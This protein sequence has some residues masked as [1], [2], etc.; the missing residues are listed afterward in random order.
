MWV[1]MYAAY[2]GLSDQMQHLL[3]E[4]VA[5]HDTGRVFA[6]S[7]YCHEEISDREAGRLRSMGAEHPVVRTHPQTRRKGLFVNSHFTASIKG[8]KSAESAALLNFLYDHIELPDFTCRV[9]WQPARLP[10]GT[11]AA[12]STAPSATIAPP[13]A[14]WNGSQSTVTARSILAGGNFAVAGHRGG[15]FSFSARQ[16]FADRE[17]ESTRRS[18]I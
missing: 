18:V 16:G 9:R 3:S 13:G 15:L 17:H 1:S 12:L 2:E 14:A 5:I 7:A 10:C 8:M 6:L 4:L 11:I